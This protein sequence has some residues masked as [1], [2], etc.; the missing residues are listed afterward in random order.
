MMAAA[1]S[2]FSKP[3]AVMEEDVGAHKREHHAAVGRYPSASGAVVHG[4][5][6]GRLLASTSSRVQR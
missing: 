1:S 2:H 6:L 3:A 5:S 4:S